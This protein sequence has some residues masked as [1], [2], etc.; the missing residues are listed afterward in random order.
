MNSCFK[1]RS[2][3]WLR[4]LFHKLQPLSAVIKKDHLG[5]HAEA[6]QPLTPLYPE[7]LEVA[8]HVVGTR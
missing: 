4:L 5:A 7:Q 6:A 8:Q 2:N 3:G 1:G